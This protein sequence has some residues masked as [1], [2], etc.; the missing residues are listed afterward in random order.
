MLSAEFIDWWFAPWHGNASVAAVH[1]T[2]IGMDA[3]LLG[4]RDGYRNWC[5][6]AAITSELPQQFDPQWC[7]TALID[8][9]VLQRA[10]ELFMGLIAARQPLQTHRA[11]LNRLRVED[12]KWCLSL[13]TT[14]LLPAYCVDHPDADDSL[15]VRGLAEV[16]LR[17][18]A[19]FV[20]LWPRLRMRL[21]TTQQ[22]AVDLR[23]QNS[24][25]D[26]ATIQRAAIRS[27]RC[28][29]ICIQRSEVNG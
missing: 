9:G 16:A 24:W 19:G 2:P 3:D 7:D 10:A 28:W 23:T 1:A 26:L 18:N 29:R 6:Q 8:P 15:M 4:Q 17:L 14:Q 12:R 25:A 27:Q 22:A 13:A 11:T 21:P 20:G 5:K